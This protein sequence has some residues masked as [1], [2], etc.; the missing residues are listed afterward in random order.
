[1]GYPVKHFEV[2][3]KDA[4]ALGEFYGSAF[5]WRIKQQLPGYA[6]VFPGSEG[7]INGG[8]GSAMGS[9]VGHVTFYVEVPDLAAM[10]RKIQDLGGSTAMGPVD[11][12]DGPRIAMFLDPE[13]HMVGLVESG[14]TRQSA[15]A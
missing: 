10:L 12:P 7:G 4:A 14:S 13:G 3:G 8:V 15:T 9:A 11:V 2:V 5:D 1:M 6:M